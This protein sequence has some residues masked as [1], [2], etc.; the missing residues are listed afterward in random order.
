MRL[1]KS[2]MVGTL[3]AMVAS[4]LILNAQMEFEVASVRP[5]QLPNINVRWDGRTFVAM[6]ATV[7]KLILL[8]YQVPPV[9]A[10]RRS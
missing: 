4:I 3:A 10:R 9:S 5:S 7:E 1:A 8:A 2:V 6:G